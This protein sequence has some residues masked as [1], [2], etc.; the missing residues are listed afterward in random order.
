MTSYI[1]LVVLDSIVY[2]TGCISQNGVVSGD[3]DVAVRNKVLF[4]S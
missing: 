3:G 4:L 2:V 1:M